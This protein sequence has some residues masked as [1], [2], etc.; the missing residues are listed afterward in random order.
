[1][2]YRLWTLVSRMNRDHPKYAWLPLFSVALADFY[3]YL[4][5]TG[6]ISDVRFF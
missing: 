5:A 3:V 1:V 2:R 6:T 4:L